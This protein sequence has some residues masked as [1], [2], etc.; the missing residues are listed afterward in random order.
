VQ[1]STAGLQ[2]VDRAV[3]AHVANEHRIL[4]PLEK[5]E[6]AALDAGLARLLA[7]LEAGEG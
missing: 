4:A 3:E 7:V 1:L 5:K 6:L 2:L